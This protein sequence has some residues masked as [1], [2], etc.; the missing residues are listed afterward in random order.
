MFIYLAVLGLSCGIWGSLVWHANSS[1]QHVE[2]SS[3]TWDYPGPLYWGCGILATG[4]PGKPYGPKSDPNNSEDL[5]S[6]CL[7]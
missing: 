6:N 3:L 2:S 5:T 7:I 4:T 1:L